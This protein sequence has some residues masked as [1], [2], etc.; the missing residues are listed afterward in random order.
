MGYYQTHFAEDIVKD[1]I[2]KVFKN[3]FN[4]YIPTKDNGIDILLTD[5][6]N[7]K[8]VTIQVKWS[9]NHHPDYENQ[10]D[11]FGWFTFKKNKL[12]KSIADFWVIVV[13]QSFT[14][15]FKFVVVKPSELISMYKKFNIYDDVV[16]SYLDISGNKVFESRG[17]SKIERKD[18]INSKNN[19]N[20]PREFVDVL[21]NW[22]RIE[23]LM[24]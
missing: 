7:K 14:K 1:E 3:R 21:N 19:T 13:P 9:K 12:E 18:Q 20:N 16:N 4:V 17:L 5:K 23:E 2:H 11:C 22:A 15:K 8:N 6:E 24:K 10:N